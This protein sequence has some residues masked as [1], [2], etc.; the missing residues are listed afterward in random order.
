MDG[1]VPQPGGG[2]FVSDGGLET[3]L[4]F[5]Y[6]LELPEFAAFPMVGSETGREVLAAYYGRY[7]AIARAAQIGLFLEAPTWRANPDWAAKL[8]YDSAAL[9]DANRESIALLK[10]LRASYDDI[11]A[12]AVSGIIG[13]RGDGYVAE[14]QVDVDESAAYHRPQL[15]AFAAA[16]A[17]L[18]AAYTMTGPEEAAG[19]VR[20]AASVGLPVAICFTVE[21]DGRLPDGTS[22]G[23]AVEQVDAVGPVAYFGVNCAH[24]THIARGLG[25]G[26]WLDRIAALLPNASTRSHAELDEAQDL[27]E[28]D[29]DKLATAVGE[30]SDRLP[31]L[32]V[33]GGCCG[34]DNR[35]VAALW[36][37]PL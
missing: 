17:D 9:A 36:G 29:P 34:T 3:D 19:I 4:I 10:R 21:T 20:A 28:G 1:A 12:V 22:L 33:L 7:A 24:P 2:Q 16:G 30:L 27:D 11:P 8:G 5:H 25:D 18:A 15:E 32:S 37:L 6:G 14:L 23:S 26:A 35:H 13:P 31:G